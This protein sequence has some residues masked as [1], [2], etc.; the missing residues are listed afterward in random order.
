MALKENESV[1]LPR[2]DKSAYSGKGDRAPEEEWPTAEAPVDV[3]LF[4][5]WMLGFI[6]K[7]DTVEGDLEPINDMLADYKQWNDMVDS[8]M[9][10]RIDQLDYVF[11]WRLQAEQKMREGGKSGMTDDEVCFC[12]A[13]L[14]IQYLFVSRKSEYEYEQSIRG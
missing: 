14:I 10:V 11:D 7:E 4:E 8:W 6:P 5:G 2:Y 9:V 13:S 1:A 12:L 3:I